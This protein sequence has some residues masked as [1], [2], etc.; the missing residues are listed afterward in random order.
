M[1]NLFLNGQRMCT[2]IDSLWE[3][4]FSFQFLCKICQIVFFLHSVTTVYQAFFFRCLWYLLMFFIIEDLEETM[5]KVL[6]YVMGYYVPTWVSAKVNSLGWEKWKEVSIPRQYNL[7]GQPLKI[8]Q[9]KTGSPTDRVKFTK[10]FSQRRHLLKLP[11]KRVHVFSEMVKL[12]WVDITKVVLLIL[13]I[14]LLS[15]YVFT[16]SRYRGC[17]PLTSFK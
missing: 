13:D 1:R 2:S 12:P 11:Q 3:Q 17:R 4:K 15:K 6:R 8:D 5:M 14:E 16:I 7:Q 9:K 10:L